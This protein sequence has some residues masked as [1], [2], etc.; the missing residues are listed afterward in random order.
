MEV[1]LK[2]ITVLQE[3]DTI[4]DAVSCGIEKPAK[5]TDLIPTCLKRRN[6]EFPQPKLSIS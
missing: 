6:C 2:K 5:D 1:H 4:K 3:L